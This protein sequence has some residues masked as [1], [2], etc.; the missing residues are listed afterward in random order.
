[1]IY[2]AAGILGVDPGPL[3]ARELQWMAMARSEWV[4]GLLSWKQAFEINV[5]PYRKKG[6]MAKPDDI[7][8]MKAEKRSA[9]T[10]VSVAEMA[11]IFKTMATK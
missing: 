2:E 9:G 4:W 11:A 1:M 8:P 6:R 10:K 5:S 3:T 7:N